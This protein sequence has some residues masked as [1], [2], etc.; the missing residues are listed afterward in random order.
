MRQLG[1]YII[2]NVWQI[3]KLK[4]INYKNESAKGHMKSWWEFKKSGIFFRILNLESEQVIIVTW[5][6][7][8]IADKNQ[9]NQSLP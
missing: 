2:K 7:A 5:E 9:L 8:R 6:N 3:D 4:I 1:G